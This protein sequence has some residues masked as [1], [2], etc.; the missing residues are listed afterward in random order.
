VAGIEVG[1]GGG[2]E[3]AE[4]FHHASFIDRESSSLKDRQETPP[5]PPPSSAPFK[6]QHTSRSAR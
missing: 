1:S 2:M 4:P 5:M 6:S 3:S